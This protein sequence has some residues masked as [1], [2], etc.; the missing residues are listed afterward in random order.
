MH[1]TSQKLTTQDHSVFGDLYVR[2][3]HSDAEDQHLPPSDMG[4]VIWS[5]NVSM[6]KQVLKSLRHAL[7]IQS[8][9]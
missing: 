7:H 9:D 3:Q 4:K 8:P 6:L 1:D 2:E 5:L